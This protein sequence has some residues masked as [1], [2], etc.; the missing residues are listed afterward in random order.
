MNIEDVSETFAQVLEWFGVSSETLRGPVQSKGGKQNLWDD[1]ISPLSNQEL[2]DL[3]AKAKSEKDTK[4]LQRVVK[5]EKRR[6]D[7]N[8]QKR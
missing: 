6:G 2:Q 4:T 8:K 1:E 3:K 7:R 5:E